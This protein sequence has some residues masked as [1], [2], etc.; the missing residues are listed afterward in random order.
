MH[1][2]ACGEDDSTDKQ[3]LYVLTVFQYF[4]SQV[5]QENNECLTSYLYQSERTRIELIGDRG[6][7]NLFLTCTRHSTED[8]GLQQ[9]RCD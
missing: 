8:T 7:R 3:S 6:C 4:T 2:Y 9:G 5:A 1:V